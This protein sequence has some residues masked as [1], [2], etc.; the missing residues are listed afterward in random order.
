MTWFSRLIKKD[1]SDPSVL[2]IVVG[3]H[4]ALPDS[5]GNWHS[6]SESAQGIFSGRCVYKALAKA[7]T[8]SRKHVYILASHSHFYME[9]I[10][11]TEFWQQHGGTIVPGWIVGT[12]GAVRYRLPANPPL[13]AKTDVYGYVLATVNAGGEPGVIQFVFKQISGKDAVPQQTRNTFPPNLVDFCFDQNRDT[14]PAAVLP[15]P[16]DAACPDFQ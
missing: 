14:R 13:H 6:M 10:Y 1:R 16:P 11:D 8:E 7:Q 9:D 4:K 5:L 3:M 12:A 15:E 2:S